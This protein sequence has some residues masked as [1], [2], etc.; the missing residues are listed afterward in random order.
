VSCARLLAACALWLT[1][2]TSARAQHVMLDVP[3]CQ[4]AQGA[5]V[6]KLAALEL[7][8]R[9]SVIESSPTPVLTG[10]V[11]CEPPHAHV[12]VVDPARAQPLT[13]H[14]DLGAAAPQARQRLLALALAEL[15]TTSQMEGEA[16][17]LS[18]EPA[19]QPEPA[20]STSDDHAASV[21]SPLS[22]WL[23]PSVA[24]AADPAL[25]LLGGD[26]GVS[27]ALGP[28]LLSIDARA[29]FGQSVRSSSEV[30]MRVLALGA[31]AGLLILDRDVQLSAG[32]GLRIG[33]VALT[34]HSPADGLA[35][36]DLAAVWLGPALTTALQAPLT[37]PLLLRAGLEVGYVARPVVGFDE[38]RADRLALRGPW[39]S[40][41]LGVAL[42][43]P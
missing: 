10:S 16:P 3:D 14:I 42:R 30:Q 15:I 11:R 9:L 40:L 7:A 12:I 2:A 17:A 35:A 4:G 24:L 36:K 38:D 19:T 34:T 5:E 1:A 6:E 29:G 41:G 20:P 33:H 32:P 13:I 21:R 27:H 37:G 28:V 26:V 43:A 39:L 31:F 18:P 23:A 25:A 8:P 22:V